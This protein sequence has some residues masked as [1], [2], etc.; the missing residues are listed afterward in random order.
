MGPCMKPAVVALV[1]CDQGPLCVAGPTNLVPAGR[2]S[3]SSF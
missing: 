2:A 1:S 3:A